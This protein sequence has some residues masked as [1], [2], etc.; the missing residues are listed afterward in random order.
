MHLPYACDSFFD[1]MAEMYLG[2]EYGEVKMLPQESDVLPTA[3]QT[4]SYFSRNVPLKIP[5]V[6]AAMDNVTESKMATAIAKLGGIGV[7]HRHLSPKDQ[8]EEIRKV[9]RCLNALIDKPETVYA[10][11]MMSEVSALRKERGLP[12]RKFPVLDAERK[13]VGMLTRDEFDF[14]TDETQLIERVMTPIKITADPNTTLDEAYAIMCEHRVRM[15]PLVTEDNRLVAMYVFS[16][17]NRTLKDKSS[18]FNVDANGRL[19]VAAAIGVADA[20]ARCKEFPDDVDAVVIDTAH[21]HSAS[22]IET[23]QLLKREG[24][25]C[26]IVAGNASSGDATS[27]L[28]NAGADGIK[29]GQGPGSI[30]TTQIVSGHGRGQL[31]AVHE[32]A[33]RIRDFDVP[34]CADGGISESGHIANAIGAGAACVMLGG[35]FAGCEETPGDIITVNGSPMK[36]YRGMGSQSAMQ[37]V[38]SNRERYGQAEVPPEKVVPEGVESYVPYKGPLAQELHNLVG[39]LKAGM[40]YAGARTIKDLQAKALFERATSEGVRVAHPHD[41]MQIVEAPNHPRR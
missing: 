38:R 18:M 30:C 5:L 28:F 25:R 19:R 9:K 4:N 41:V 1:K 33:R 23:V 29:I 8:G 14:C 31:T 27:R 17:V 35:L 13:V 32:S 36:R 12:Y 6:S 26:D 10:Y 37:Q 16:D 34:I 20:L 21:A 7:I 40:G 39:G 2:L 15:L 22:V 24:L 3:T 11:Q